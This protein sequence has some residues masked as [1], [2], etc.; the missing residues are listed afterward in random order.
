LAVFESKNDQRNAAKSAIKHTTCDL[1]K[2]WKLH[3]NMPESKHDVKEEH[4]EKEMKIEHFTM[5]GT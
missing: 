2:I 3:N 1:K 4:I 5:S